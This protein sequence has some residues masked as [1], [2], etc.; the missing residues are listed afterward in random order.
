MKTKGLVLLCG[1][2][3]FSIMGMAQERAYLTFRTTDGTEHSVSTKNL[4]I[5]FPDGQMKAATEGEELVL[6]LTDLQLMFFSAQPTAIDAVHDMAGVPSIVGGQLLLPS[7][8]DGQVVVYSLD[9]RV[10]GTTGLTRGVYI[11]RWNG[12]TYKVMA[13]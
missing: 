9:G 11:V 13:Q 8:N 4:K 3:F 12:R 7:G 2:L 10:T 1:A 6:P 5:T